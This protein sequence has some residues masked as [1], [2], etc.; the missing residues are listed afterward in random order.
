MSGHTLPFPV[1]KRLRRDPSRR[2][3]DDFE[4]S[5]AVLP[6]AVVKVA[7]KRPTRILPDVPGFDI[8]SKSEIKRDT[9][10]IS[11]YSS[12]SSI[13][14]DSD[15]ED[16]ENEEDDS[17]VL[18][19]IS[20]APIAPESTLTK[21]RKRY[22]SWVYNPGQITCDLNSYKATLSML[23][24]ELN[25]TEDEQETWME[26]VESSRGEF[27]TLLSSLHDNVSDRKNQN[28]LLQ[29]LCASES[30]TERKKSH[31]N[32]GDIFSELK[33]CDEV[34][35][36]QWL[37][38]EAFVMGS[39]V[40][41]SDPQNIPVI[42]ITIDDFTTA[43]KAIFRSPIS[44]SNSRSVTQAS[45]AV[46][47]MTVE[48]TVKNDSSSTVVSPS[49]LESEEDH[50]DATAQSVFAGMEAK[51]KHSEAALADLE[52][53]FAV[54]SSLQSDQEGEDAEESKGTTLQA[55]EDRPTVDN[56]LSMKSTSDWR[57]LLE[58]RSGAIFPHIRHKK[59]KPG[60]SQC[61]LVPSVV[62]LR[63]SA[64]SVTPRGVPLILSPLSSLGDRAVAAAYGRDETQPSAYMYNP[65][66]LHIAGLPGRLVDAEKE[67][68][69]QVWLQ[70]DILRA[71]T[72]V[73]RLDRAVEDWQKQ[74]EESS[75]A[76]AKCVGSHL[77]LSEE[78]AVS[79]G[80][81]EL[82]AGG[83]VDM[84]LPGNGSVG[85]G[86]IG[87]S[88]PFI[89]VSR[90]GRGLRGGKRGGR[91]IQ[92]ALVAPPAPF[93]SVA[94]APDLNPATLASGLLSSQSSSES[95]HP[96]AQTGALVE[97]EAKTAA[98]GED[99]QDRGEAE[100]EEGKIGESE[101]LS[102][103]AKA[104]LKRKRG[105]SQKKRGTGGARKSS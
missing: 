43:E 102:A 54:S 53:F 49:A 90:G 57:S 40:Q 63:T 1:K 101:D 75:A 62:E 94:P 98:S 50:K 21:K 103:A 8:L 92:K 104:D 105:G 70:S 24:K 61:A 28:R 45:D 67:L 51:L 89:G 17:Y 15:S 13:I 19:S 6:V 34:L 29:M 38:Y 82:A 100:A 91:V 78:A 56:L 32:I 88:T 85:T 59:R 68:S 22:S 87:H 35:D 65:E 66:Q 5:R 58:L 86:S 47:G 48:A 99:S 14:R 3:G 7:S 12:A 74:A 26:A 80:M 55:S 46:T 79:A 9:K 31:T 72:L 16:N 4:R 76:L 27:T 44:R 18:S 52:H 95:A 33:S 96:S 73:Q 64:M 83:A 23:Q 25:K 69:K 37:E 10:D 39:S 2:A 36:K 77:L 42:S 60:A 93:Y 30:S 84:G 20:K 11:K 41:D 97:T 81:R 71:N